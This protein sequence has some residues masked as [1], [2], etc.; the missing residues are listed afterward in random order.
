[1]AS[2]NRLSAKQVNAT[3]KP[4]RYADVP[5]PGVKVWKEWTTPRHPR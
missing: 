4:G 3:R 5:R 2:F 1:M